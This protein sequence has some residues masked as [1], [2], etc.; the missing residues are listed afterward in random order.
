MP[1]FSVR[2]KLTDGIIIVTPEYN[3]DY[4]ASLKNVVNLLYDE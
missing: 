1:D 3:G 4:P 2:K